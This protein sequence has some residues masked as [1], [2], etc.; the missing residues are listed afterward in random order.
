MTSRGGKGAAGDDP[1]AN[2]NLDD[3][4]AQAA[5]VRGRTGLGCQERTFGGPGPAGNATGR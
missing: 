5:T 3:A 2:V 1:F 4:W